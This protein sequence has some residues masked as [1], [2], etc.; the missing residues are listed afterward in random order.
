MRPPAG[1]AHGQERVVV[2]VRPDTVTAEA[3]GG[4]VTV[5]IDDA[6]ESPGSSGILRHVD[7]CAD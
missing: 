1:L 4:T 3:A 2:G 7:G 5:L 6:E